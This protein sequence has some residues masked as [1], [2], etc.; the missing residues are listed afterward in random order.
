[1]SKIFLICTILTMTMKINILNKIIQ[2]KQIEREITVIHIQKE[3][4]AEV[5]KFIVIITSISI[6]GGQNESWSTQTIQM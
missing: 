4:C 6:F 3:Y 1:M 5:I 2:F